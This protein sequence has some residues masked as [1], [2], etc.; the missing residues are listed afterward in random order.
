[1]RSKT[2]FT[3]IACPNDSFKFYGLEGKTNVVENGTSVS[4]G[5][6]VRKYICLQCGE[7][8]NDHTG[9]FYYDLVKKSELSI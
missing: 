1:M 6:T 7:V 3:D 4:R 8:F 2:Q 5:E 9:T